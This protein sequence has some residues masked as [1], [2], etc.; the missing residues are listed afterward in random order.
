MKTF[1]IEKRVRESLGT[2]RRIY[3][4]AVGIIFALMCGNNLWEK[5][6]SVTSFNTIYYVVLLLVCI[7]ILIFGIIGKEPIKTRYR[8]MIDNEHLISKKTFEFANKIKLK[9]ITHLKFFFP[10][11]DVTYRDFVK[12]YEFSWLS[13]EEYEKLKTCLTEYC[14]SKGIATN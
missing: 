14:Q 11:L 1:F 9:S 5:G 10:R 4:I 12:T 3:N 13:E 2:G 6:F 8:L 7:F